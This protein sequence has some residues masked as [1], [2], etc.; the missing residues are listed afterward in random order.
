MEHVD[1]IFDKASDMCLPQ[2]KEDVSC[3][4]NIFFPKHLEQS[5][6]YVFVSH[7]IDDGVEHGR[8][9]HEEHWQQPVSHTGVRG[10]GK[11]VAEDWSDVENTDHGE[12]SPAGG[13]G[14]PSAL[15]RS[16]SEHSNHNV[17]V[18][19]DN[20]ST[21]CQGHQKT[22]EEQ[23]TLISMCTRA[24]EFEQWREITEEV[25]DEVWPAE[26]EE[27]CQDGVGEGIGQGKQT[28]E[29]AQGQSGS[30]AHKD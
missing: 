15:S 6:L 3:L 16:N 8:K 12:V 21:G 27:R 13:K 24:G 19:D 29:W 22:E 5:P 28:G 25:C 17:N 11:N 2:H 23:G 9:D 20:Q 7:A 10:A 14:F 1:E 18:G 4:S 30:A 26:L